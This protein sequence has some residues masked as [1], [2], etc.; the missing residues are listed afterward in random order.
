[1]VASTTTGQLRKC[2]S[3]VDFPAASVTIADE[4]DG[5]G[6]GKA[7]TENPIVDELGENRGS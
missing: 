2:L 4:R 3:N 5:D 7:A 6:A 1:M